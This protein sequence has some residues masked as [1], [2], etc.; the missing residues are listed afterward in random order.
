M[1]REP[2]HGFAP[3]SQERRVLFLARRNLNVKV[4]GHWVKVAMDEKGI[5]GPFGSLR[6]VYVL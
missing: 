3:N 6:A 4:K 2:L 1:S 5:F